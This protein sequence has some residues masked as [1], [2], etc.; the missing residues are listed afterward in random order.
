ME[1]VEVELIG[2]IEVEEVG[3]EMDEEL[4]CLME[5]GEVVEQLDG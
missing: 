5:E 1:E 3:E 2:W 4:E